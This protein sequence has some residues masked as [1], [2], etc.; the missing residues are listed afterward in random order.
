MALAV[1][2]AFDL[3]SAEGFLVRQLLRPNRWF[4]KAECRPGTQLRPETRRI[5]VIAPK[6]EDLSDQIKLSV[7]FRM[8][9]KRDGVKH[10]DMQYLRPEVG[11]WFGGS[12]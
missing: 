10:K 11:E 8:A 7:D 12:W 9:C 6:V 2:S 4:R 3:S 1:S 5:I